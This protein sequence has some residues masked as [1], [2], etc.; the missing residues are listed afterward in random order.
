MFIKAKSM[1]WK[2]LK[3]KEKYEEKI[4]FNETE[5]A[6]KHLQHGVAGR[7]VVYAILQFLGDIMVKVASLL[8]LYDSERSNRSVY[9]QLYATQISLVFLMAQ[10]FSTLNDFVTNRCILVVFNRVLEICTLIATGGGCFIILTFLLAKHGTLTSEDVAFYTIYFAMCCSS[11]FISL[12]L[13]L[14]ERVCFTCHGTPGHIWSI[15]PDALNEK[16]E[17]LSLHYSVW[18]TAI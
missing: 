18:N 2:N 15:S 3:D 8:V 17:E 6:Y 1:K 12:P 14:L 10:T 4:R 11:L 13:I 5:L 9:V 16:K 7:F